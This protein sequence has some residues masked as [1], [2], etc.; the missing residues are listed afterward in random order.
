MLFKIVRYIILQDTAVCLKLHSECQLTLIRLFD[1][2]LELLFA[3]ESVI[4]LYSYLRNVINSERTGET[5][6]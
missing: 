3:V 4:E 5:D 1:N 2:K 6:S